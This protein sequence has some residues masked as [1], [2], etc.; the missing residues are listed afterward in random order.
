MR[1]SEVDPT[2]A[3]TPTARTGTIFG[4]PFID[5]LNSTSRRPTIHLFSHF[6]D[7]P[8]FVL[9]VMLHHCSS[10]DYAVESTHP[11][12]YIAALCCC[13]CCYCFHCCC[14]LHHCWNPHAVNRPL[15]IGCH[16]CL[17]YGGLV[18]VFASTQQYHF[19]YENGGRF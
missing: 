5:A 14:C 2:T 12:I 6:A 3:K 4:R 18:E 10:V 16:V 1:R 11:S 13:G 9:L 7:K 19:F 17:V 8:S 15:A